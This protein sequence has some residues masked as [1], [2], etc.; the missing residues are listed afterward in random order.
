MLLPV[1][2]DGATHATTAVPGAVAATV[3]FVGLVAPASG[4]PV[5]VPAE[6]TVSRELFVKTTR[7]R[8]R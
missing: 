7:T 6:P 2:P 3:T 1:V 5:I 4:A 8:K